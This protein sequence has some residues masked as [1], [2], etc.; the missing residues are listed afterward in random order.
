LLRLI[1]TPPQNLKNSEVWF[2]TFF[3]QRANNLQSWKKYQLPTFEQRQQKITGRGDCFIWQWYF[4]FFHSKHCFRG[5]CSRWVY[6]Y[7]KFPHVV[8]MFRICIVFVH[9]NSPDVKRNT[10]I[11]RNQFKN[12]PV[13]WHFFNLTL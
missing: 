8:C 9:Q 2:S 7:S 3:N 5:E 4:Y 13:K 10:H 1:T 6:I 11:L 12:L